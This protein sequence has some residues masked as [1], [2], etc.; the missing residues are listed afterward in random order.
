MESGWQASQWRRFAVVIGLAAVAAGCVM[1]YLFDPAKGGF[2]LCVFHQ[3]TGLDC[4][5]CGTQ[6][7]LHQLFHGNFAAAWRFNPFAVALMPVAVWLIAREVIWLVNGK[8]LPGV[9]TRPSFA[10]ALVA[11]LIIFGVLRNV[12]KFQ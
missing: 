6:R 9:V 1:L 8:R 4:P 10:W 11:G 12:S 2:P 3:L 7:A 5:G